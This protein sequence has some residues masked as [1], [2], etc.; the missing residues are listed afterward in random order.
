MTISST[1]QKEEKG[2]KE[3]WVNFS[4][5]SKF[6]EYLIISDLL[7][8]LKKKGVKE[9]EKWGGSF[10]N[11]IMLNYGKKKKILCLIVNLEY[12]DSLLMSLGELTL[13]WV[14]LNLNIH[15]WAW[16]HLV[17]FSKTC[18]C[19]WLKLVSYGMMHII[20][21][22]ISLPFYPKHKP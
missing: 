9:R 14:H 2:E 21:I 22:F 20:K 18:L 3:D 11:D 10:V 19:S 12:F 15:S 17:A 16:I 7:F 4:T 5:N 13:T 1:Q 6:E 8:H